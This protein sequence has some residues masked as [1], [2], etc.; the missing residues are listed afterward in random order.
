MQ[1]ALE[2]VFNANSKKYYT[3]NL[4]PFLKLGSGYLYALAGGSGG[5]GGLGGGK[6]GSEGGSPGGAGG[7]GFGIVLAILAIIVVV[8]VCTRFL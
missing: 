6:G 4:K 7:G 1:K 8:G 3:N 2:N 5:S